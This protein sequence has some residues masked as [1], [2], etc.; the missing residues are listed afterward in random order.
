[1]QFLLYLVARVV[2]AVVQALPLRAVARIGRVCG[3]LAYWVDARHRRVALK[4]LAQCFGGEKSPAEI[5]ALARENFRRLGETYTTAVKTAAMSLADLQPHLTMV[6][7]EHLRLVADGAAPQPSSLVIA[8]GHFGNFELY[9]RLGA[10]APGYRGMTTYRGLRQ[11][12]LNRLLQT[13]RT[14]SGCLFFD[15]RSDAAALKAQLSQPGFMLGL[16][17]D[18]RAAKGAVPVPFFG[19][20]CLTNAAPAVFA[21]RY[22]AA[23]HTAI[24]YR[25]GLARWRIEVGP[26]IPTHANGVARPTEDLMREVN[27]ALEGAVRRDPAN[28]FWVHDRW[29]MP[30]TT[31]QMADG[32]SQP[33]PLL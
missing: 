1:M 14:R 20:D 16:L 33:S 11:P 6:G 10:L 27:Q 25:V 2:V 30:P 17:V 5:R 23:L 19:R 22:Q 7:G 15:R 29:R 4:N 9:S 28:W 18:Q 3:A 21:R 13:L 12:G 31:Q 24:C 32:A 8:I 26:E